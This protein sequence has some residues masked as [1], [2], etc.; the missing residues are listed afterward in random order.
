MKV[1]AHIEDLE[2][3]DV[4]CPPRNSVSVADTLA[5][6]RRTPARIQP[7]DEEP[8]SQRRVCMID[9]FLIEEPREVSAC[10]PMV[11]GIYGRALRVWSRCHFHG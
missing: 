4:V 2:V 6:T 1:H 5:E 11:S 7:F 8:D 9:Q 10:S 3:R